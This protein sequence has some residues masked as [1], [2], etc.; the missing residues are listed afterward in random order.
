LTRKV[1]VRVRVR[2]RISYLEHE[3]LGVLLFDAECRVATHQLLERVLAPDVG[4]VLVRVRV[5]VR[6]RVRARVRARVRVRVRVRV[7]CA[8]SWSN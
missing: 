1:R 3:L 4:E 2:V 7:T 6:I 5:R 8:L